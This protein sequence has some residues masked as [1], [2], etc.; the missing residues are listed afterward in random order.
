MSHIVLL[1]DDDDNV[2]HGLARAL[3]RQPYQLYTARSGEEAMF[4]LKAHA[5]DVVVADE[6]MPGMSGSDLLAWVA[7]TYP[8]VMRI[9]LTG[10]ATAETA[11]RAINEGAV[12]HF[13]S[14]PCHE[15]QLAV[16]IRKALEHK[17]L[18]DENRRLLQL[19][20]AQLQQQQG[21][22]EDLTTLLRL[23]ADDLQGPLQGL[24]ESCHDGDNRHQ[25]GLDR[26]TERL[27]ADALAAAAAAQRLV[28]HLLTA[29]PVP[30][31]LEVTLP[32]T[33]SPTSSSLE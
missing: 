9:I 23:I 22:H 26:E 16:T 29:S 21:L 13:F 32:L 15:V 14:K 4:I 3:R 28:E 17:D 30:E 12:Y 33:R 19:R 8:E 25:A 27:L 7:R 20:R 6:Q 18:L 24:L 11:I 1:V 31:E 10:R 2:L 5:V